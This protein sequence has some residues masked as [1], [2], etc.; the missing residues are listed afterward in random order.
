M[1]RLP[2]HFALSLLA[3]VA[4]AGC[5]ATQ[6]ADV[7]NLSDPR[8]IVDE[9][10]DGKSVTLRQGRALV[11]RLAVNS[12]D[13]NRWELAP[14]TSTP[15]GS[16][17]L[18]DYQ[19]SEGG[20]ALAPVPPYS[21]VL[22]WLNP[23]GTPVAPTVIDASNPAPLVTQGDVVLRLRGMSP[24]NATVQLDYRAVATPGGP[25]AKTVRFDVA[26]VQ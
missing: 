1:N 6:F 8:T 12:G 26:V 11:V 23:P 25:A 14:L 3:A 18:I 24:G 21:G 2:V 17:V 5:A 19:A 20:A 10:I 13:G 15:V 7:A 9:S 22:A 4:V 16:P